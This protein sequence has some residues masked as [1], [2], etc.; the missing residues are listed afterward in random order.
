M[1]FPHLPCV[2]VLALVATGCAAGSRSGVQ[3]SAHSYNGANFNGEWEVAGTED[4]VPEDPLWLLPSAF[5]IAS[6]SHSLQLLDDTGTLLAEVALDS[7][8]PYSSAAPAQRDIQ[9][10]PKAQWLG[11]RTFAYERAVP[12][13]F[14]V[15]RTFA[16]DGKGRQLKV[17][18][19]VSAEGGAKRSITRM[20]RRV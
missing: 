13:S 19:A 8:Y 14:R 11:P 1:K 7:D 20:Y 12:D 15:T 3:S 5:K 16:L 4:R 18:L 10:L 17:A 9:D 6:D 2:A